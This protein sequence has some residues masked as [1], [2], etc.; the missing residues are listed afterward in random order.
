[1]GKK[2]NKISKD[3]VPTGFTLSM[4]LVDM[5]PVVFFGLSAIKIGALFHSALFMLGAWICLISGTVKV[6]WKLIVAVK[7]KNIWPL[8]IQMRIAM[9]IGF[10]FLLIALIVNS[11]NIQLA[12]INAAIFAFPSVIFFGLGIIGMLC[13]FIFAFAMDSSDPKVNW[14]EQGV[15]GLA[16]ICIFIGLMLIH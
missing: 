6:L 8:F 9:P 4:A 2:R 13:M 14:L 15:N 16:Q 10:C 3:I 7:K 11:S 12:A 5:V 1:M